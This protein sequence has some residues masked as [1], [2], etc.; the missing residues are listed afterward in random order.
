[1]GPFR[2]CRVK[3]ATGITGLYRRVDFGV[4]RALLE[5]FEF[6]SGLRYKDY[7]GFAQILLVLVF[8]FLVHLYAASC[9]IS[10]CQYSNLT[11]L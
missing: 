11:S 10:A 4:P 3:V 9:E 1:M 6:P 7:Q 5:E 2:P 8:D